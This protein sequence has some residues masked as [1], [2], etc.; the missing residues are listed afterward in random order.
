MTTTEASLDRVEEI[1]DEYLRLDLDGIFL[2][3]LS[4]YGFA[5]KT[6]AIRKYDATRWL[7]FYARGLRYVLAANRGGR[8]FPQF[9][10][11]LIP[12]RMLT[13]RT[14]GYVDLRSPAGIGLGALVYN[15]DGKV[16]ASD[17]GRMLAEMGDRTFELG[18]VADSYRALV[19]S[20]KLIDLVGSS[21]TQCAPECSD[22]AYEAHCGADPVYH[23]ATQADP[24]G[25]K[26]LSDFCA[27]QKG[28]MN[29]LLDILETSSQDAAILR[30]W[31]GV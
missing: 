19:C 2:R 3:P 12:K 20:D 18:S 26:P 23:H 24:V 9:Y 29:L 7:D 17:E 30:R 15:Y 21:L 4:P 13:D 22:C 27:R 25:I 31:A 14:L 6:R 28:V 1:V 10:A 5:V 8:H 11:A 16:C